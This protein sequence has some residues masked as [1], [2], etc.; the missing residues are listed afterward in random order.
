MIDRDLYFYLARVL[1]FVAYVC[2]VNE[3]FSKVQFSIIL[4]KF[5]IPALTL[6]FLSLFIVRSVLNI[7]EPNPL[8]WEIKNSGDLRF[9]LNIIHYSLISILLSSS[10][11]NYFYYENKKSFYLFFGTFSLTILEL[12]TVGYFYV[13]KESFTVFVA[14]IFTA[15]SFYFF[16]KQA[17][18][19]YKPKDSVF[20]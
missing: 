20:T 1:F 6:L 2:L 17:Q 15:L 13:L 19:T 10:L 4:R 7:S 12:L 9:Y 11:L 5:K 14:C 18:L 3:I 16:L 8:E